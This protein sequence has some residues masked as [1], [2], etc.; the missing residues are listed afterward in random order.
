M[1]S[2][3]LIQRTPV[4]RRKGR[5]KIIKTAILWNPTLFSPLKKNKGFITHTTK[6]FIPHEDDLAKVATQH[7]GRPHSRVPLGI[8]LP[9][10]HA[11]YRD[12]RYGE[13]RGR[14]KRIPKKLIPKK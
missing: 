13:R 5:E 14:K 11:V 3:K 4:D 1:P 2:R 7:H 10:G 9:T 6:G 12:T 8:H